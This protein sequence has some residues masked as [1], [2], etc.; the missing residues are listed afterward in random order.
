VGA[1]NLGMA[2]GPLLSLPLSYLP[3][4]ELAGVAINP[5]TAVGLFMAL[6]WLLF[7]AC[8]AR[9]F[10]DPPARC[11][12]VGLARTEGWKGGWVAAALPLRVKMQRLPA[13]SLMVKLCFPA[14]HALLFTC[15]HRC[16][17]GCPLGWP[18]P[19]SCS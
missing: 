4:S 14:H 2:L 13:L 11:V 1:S 3:E 10:R 12:G 18:A 16:F 8:A 15:T 6:A 9:V 17:V 7:L 19:L 5:I